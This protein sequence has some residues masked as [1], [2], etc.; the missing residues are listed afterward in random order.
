MTCEEYNKLI[1]SDF[2]ASTTAERVAAKRHVGAC[3]KCRE[4]LEEEAEA[5]KNKLTPDAIKLIEEIVTAIAT[6]DNQDP[7]A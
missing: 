7:E 6:K 1:N 5:T 4:A 3:S 2:F